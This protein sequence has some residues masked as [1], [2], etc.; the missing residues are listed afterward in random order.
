[1][2][3]MLRDPEQIAAEFLADDQPYAVFID[4]NLGSRP[5]YLHRLCQ[6]LRPLDKNLECG[7]EYRCYG[8]SVADS[9]NGLGRLHGC[10]RRLRVAAPG[11][12]HR[13]QQEKPAPDDYSRRVALLHDNGIQVNGS[14]VLGFDHDRPDVF[15]RTAQWIEANRLECTTFTS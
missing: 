4:N 1:M 12:H 11:Q 15:A 3:Y 2:P 10:V 9:A 7:G 6:A 13:R 14:F 5:D 8:R